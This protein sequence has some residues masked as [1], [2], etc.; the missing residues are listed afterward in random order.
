MVRCVSAFVDDRL[1]SRIWGSAGTGSAEAAL[2]YAAP[3]FSNGTAM[4]S[5]VQLDRWPPARD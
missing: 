1:L 4:H 5:G 3:L 2:I